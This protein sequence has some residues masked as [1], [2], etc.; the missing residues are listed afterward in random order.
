MLRSRSRGRPYRDRSPEPPSASSWAQLCLETAALSD[1]DHLI[2]GHILLLS[3]AVSSPR[4]LGSSASCSEPVGWAGFGGGGRGGRFGEPKKGSWA[5]FGGGDVASQR[6]QRPRARPLRAEVGEARG[7]M[8]EIW[9]AEIKAAAFGGALRSA[10]PESRYLILRRGSRTCCEL[11]RTSAPVFCS[12]FL[13]P[14]SP[15]GAPPEQRPRGAPCPA[16]ARPS[17]FPFPKGAPALLGDGNR[18]TSPLPGGL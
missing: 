18:G 14:L 17:E 11:M 1:I 3:W 15:P 9:G 13:K 10:A 5:R 6:C 7:G 8:G 4:Q 2:W 12:R 16:R